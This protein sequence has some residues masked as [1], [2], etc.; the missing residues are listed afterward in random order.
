MNFE[1]DGGRMNEFC[2]SRPAVYRQFIGNS[3]RNRE[4]SAEIGLI[5]LMSVIGVLEKIMA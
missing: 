4:R 3:L 1:L 2:C 5:M